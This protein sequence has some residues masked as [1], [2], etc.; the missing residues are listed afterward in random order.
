ME[1]IVNRVAESEIEVLNLEALW[2]GGEVEEFD[3]APLLHL[4]LVLRE[5]E[6]RH[7]VSEYD[8][9]QFK[10]RHVALYC[11][12]EAIVPTWAYMYL[13][14]R[15]E[16]IAETVVVG[17][18]EDLLRDFFVLRLNEFDWSI[19]EDRMVVVKGCASDVVPPDA[20][21]IATRELQRRARK[22]MYGEPCSAVP[23]WRRRAN[24]ASSVVGARPAG[25]P[26]LT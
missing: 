19:Y 25:T 9:A 18:R 5:K 16:G 14:T 7:A 4:G 11:S 22:I 26:D 1:P 20:Y 12:T 6:F 24:S 17:R 2:D 13:V 15:L 23:I 10:G 3:L 8:W 21:L